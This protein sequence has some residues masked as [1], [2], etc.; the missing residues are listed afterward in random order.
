MRYLRGRF[1]KSCPTPCIDILGKI[2]DL[3]PDK[4]GKNHHFPEPYV[5]GLAEE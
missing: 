2:T 4:Y 5:G 1:I 3:S